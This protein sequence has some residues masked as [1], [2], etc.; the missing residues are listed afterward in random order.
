MG[1][2]DLRPL[3]VHQTATELLRT[4]RLRTTPPWLD[5]V[6]RVPPAQTLVRP[7]PV[8]HQENRKRPK[9]RKPS[10]MFLPQQISYPEDELR[11]EFY[12]D[13]PWE[14]AR[15]RVVLE[16]DGKD[17]QQNDWSRLH[18]PSRAVDAER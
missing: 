5:I 13:H 9:T 6:G 1:R 16:D 18:Q 2:Y 14:L 8:Q 17:A 11:R 15:P 4:P 10:R 7:Q 12:S 3:Q